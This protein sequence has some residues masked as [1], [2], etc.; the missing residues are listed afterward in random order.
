M[1]KILV[2]DDETDACYLIKEYMEEKG[3]DVIVSYNG[4]DALEKVKNLEPDI[5]LLDITMPGIDGMEVLRRVRQFNDKIGIIMVT[6][7]ND[8]SKAKE[9]IKK[10]ADDYITKPIDFDHLEES[11]LVDL[12]MRKKE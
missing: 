12:I 10:G 6:G 9:A 5:M 7:I 11:L 4:E 2:V 1:S 8:E 3:Y